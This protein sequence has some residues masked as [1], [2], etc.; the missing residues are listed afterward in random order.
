MHGRAFAGSLAA[1]VFLDVQ[2]REAAGIADVRN[3]RRELLLVVAAGFVARRPT[4]ATATATTA[5]APTTTFPGCTA[6]GGAFGSLGT[7]H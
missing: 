7:V 1:L 6:F 3:M 5:T 2:N 4:I